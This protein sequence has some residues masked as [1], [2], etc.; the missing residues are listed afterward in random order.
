MSEILRTILTIL[1]IVGAL[2]L[3]SGLAKLV[4]TVAILCAVVLAI[5]ILK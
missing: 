2:T 5:W 3:I 4:T 1:V